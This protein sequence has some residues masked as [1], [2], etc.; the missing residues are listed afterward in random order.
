MALLNLLRTAGGL[1]GLKGCIMN[2]FIKT[3][4]L[5]LIV[6]GVVATIVLIAEEGLPLSHD[7]HLLLQF[8]WLGVST[9]ALLTFTLLPALANPK[10]IAVQ[11]PRAAEWELPE[12]YAAEGVSEWYDEDRVWL[13]GHPDSGVKSE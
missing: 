2:R 7:V 1:A 9:A 3:P 6:T 10:P 8:L 11:R 4:F 5:W 13:Q 12:A